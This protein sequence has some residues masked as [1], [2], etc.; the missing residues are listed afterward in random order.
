MIKYIKSLFKQDKSKEIEDLESKLNFFSFT[1]AEL[2]FELSAKQKT[3]LD[4]QSKI[5]ESNRVG[6]IYKANE[7]EYLCKEIGRLREIN[8]ELVKNNELLHEESLKQHA[9]SKKKK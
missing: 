7:Y 9:K 2:Q 3:I 5:D 6:N 8:R 4:L 1:V